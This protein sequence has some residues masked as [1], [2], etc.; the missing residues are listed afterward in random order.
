MLRQRFSSQRKTKC[1]ERAANSHEDK[2]TRKLTELIDTATDQWDSRRQTQT[3]KHGRVWVHVTGDRC[4]GG[5]RI[6]WGRKKF[7]RWGLKL[8]SMWNW[9][10]FIFLPLLE[11][12]NSK[13]WHNPHRNYA[14]LPRRPAISFRIGMFPSSLFANWENCGWVIYPWRF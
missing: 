1:K 3:D 11:R 13:P 12:G 5:S 7:R 9:K 6:S 10:V 4:E 8:I 14:L 2:Q